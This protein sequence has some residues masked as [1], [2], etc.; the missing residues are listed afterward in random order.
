MPQKIERSNEWKK[1]VGDNWLEVSKN[2]LH[3][4]GNLILTEFNSEMGNKPLTIKKE[5]LKKSNLQYRNDI[6]NRETWNIED[7]TA[8]QAEMIHRFLLTFPLPVD[9]QQA[10]NWD[11]NKAITSNQELI[12]PLTDGIEEIVT[13]RKPVAVMVQDELYDASTWQDV[14]LILLRWLLA[15]KSIAFSRYLNTEDAAK[16]PLIAT[17]TELITLAEA[18]SSLLNKYKRL[19]DGAVFSKMKN[20]SEEDSLYVHINQSAQYLI[21]RMRHVM[22]L[23]D[24]DEE[25]VAIKLK[26]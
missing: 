20:A 23:A 13:G 17:Q 16:Y 15:N 4:I 14:Y 8:H 10:E 11:T 25:S 1:E 21:L 6:L 2:Y 26:A 7:I 12:S 5:M 24:M 19:S 18:D 3:N 22:I 9:M